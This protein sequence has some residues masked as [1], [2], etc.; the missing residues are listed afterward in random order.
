MKKNEYEIKYNLITINIIGIIYSAVLVG[1]IWLMFKFNILTGNFEYIS[2]DD[3]L[4]TSNYLLLLCII[5]FLWMGL[6]ET[7]HGVFYFF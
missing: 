1:V 5:M 2:F 3:L 4:G 7:I 6:H